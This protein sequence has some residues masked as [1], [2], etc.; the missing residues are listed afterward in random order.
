METKVIEKVTDKQGGPP[1]NTQYKIV[2]FTD[3]TKFNLFP[4]HDSETIACA[5][6]NV[7]FPVEI[8]VVKNGAFTNLTQMIP[9]PDAQK[10]AT[11]PAPPQTQQGASQSQPAPSKDK[12]ICYSYAKDIVVA[13]LGHKDAGEDKALAEQVADI[14]D[15]IF[16][17]L[18][19]KPKPT[20]AE[21][22]AIA[23][24]KNIADDPEIPF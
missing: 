7:G 20:Q 16:K 22:D 2:W 14:G 10:A 11:T 1:K 4:S 8:D 17:R 5:Y 13:L 23:S 3:G 9:L 21:L 15:E 19:A 12:S 6:A 24:S 18:T